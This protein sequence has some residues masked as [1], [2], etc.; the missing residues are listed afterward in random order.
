MKFVIYF[1]IDANFDYSKAYTLKN[2]IW[3]YG[4]FFFSIIDQLP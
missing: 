2:I 3:I 4:P 1:S